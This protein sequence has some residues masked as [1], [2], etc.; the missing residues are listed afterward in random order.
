M[1][2]TIEALDALKSIGLNLYERKIFVA[3]LAKGIATAAEVSEIAKV[4]RSRSYDVLESLAE[5]GFVIVQPSKPIKY[6]ALKPSDALERTKQVLEKGFRDMTER[7]DKIRVSPLIG[8]L[9]SIYQKGFNLVQPSEFT[10]TFKGN[11]MINRQM[12]SLFKGATKDIDIMTTE[13]G[14]ENLYSNHLR[15]LKKMSRNGVKLRIAA[16]LNNSAAAKAF[17]EIADVRNSEPLGRMCNV[18]NKNVLMMLT[19][20]SDVHETQDVAFWANSP[21]IAEKM[22]KGMFEKAWSSATEFK[23]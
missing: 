21:H 4:P 23:V 20:D 7:I 12:S 11:D 15:V 10:G 13:K 8:E 1:V 9:E 17:S 3:L 16:P 14:F 19:D 6:V 2:A 18:D 22:V 5:K